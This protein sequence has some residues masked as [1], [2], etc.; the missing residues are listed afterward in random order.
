MKMNRDGH[1]ADEPVADEPPRTDEAP[2]PAVADEQVDEELPPRLVR[3]GA[4]WRLSIIRAVLGE[5]DDEELDG[6]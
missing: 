2:N 1:R 6:A 3:V 4:A 5:L